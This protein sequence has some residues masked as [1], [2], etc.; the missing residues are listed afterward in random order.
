MDY[1]AQNE[2]GEWMDEFRTFF[3]EYLD[4]KGFDLLGA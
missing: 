4:P 1:P 3:A 2:W